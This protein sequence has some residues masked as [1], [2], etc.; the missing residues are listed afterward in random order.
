VDPD[1]VEIE[2]EQ[3]WYRKKYGRDIVILGTV[4]APYG[5][6][7]VYGSHPIFMPR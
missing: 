1:A 3:E 6:I 5:W 4:G 2:D 7:L